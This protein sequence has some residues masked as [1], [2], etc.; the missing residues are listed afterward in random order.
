MKGKKKKKPE[1]LKSD[2]RVW[3]LVS[4]FLEI[5]I[6]VKYTHIYQLLAVRPWNVT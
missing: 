6:Q 2:K 5:K 1:V 4:N 3:V